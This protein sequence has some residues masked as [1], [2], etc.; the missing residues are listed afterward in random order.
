MDT[1]NMYINHYR[2]KHYMYIAV[3]GITGK[4]YQKYDKLAFY[5]NNLPNLFLSPFYNLF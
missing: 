3:M 2:H 4:I 5:F 1:A